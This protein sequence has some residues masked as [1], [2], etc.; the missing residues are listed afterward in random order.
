MKFQS[1]LLTVCPA[2]AAAV[3]GTPTAGSTQTT[4]DINVSILLGQA[5]T[6]ELA[7]LSQ[8]DERTVIPAA[9]ELNP[10]GTQDTIVRISRLLQY[11]ALYS[12]RIHT[13]K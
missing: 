4:F 5:I 1:I 6:F 13:R 12:I 2:F 3:S 7:N 8:F 10:V 11:R 9:Q